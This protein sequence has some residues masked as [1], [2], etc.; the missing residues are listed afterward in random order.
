MEARYTADARQA[1]VLAQDEARGLGHAAVGAEHLLLGLLG[2]RDSP[3]GRAL[4][5][6][7]LTAD[8]ARADVERIL[9]R[10][11]R[12]GHGSIP[13]HP[14]AQRVLERALREAL[15]LG[16]EVVG[17]EH[18]V[19]ALLADPGSVA[20]QVL[21]AAG[22]P[23]A[24]RDRLLEAMNEPAPEGGA[25]DAPTVDR[26][27]DAVSVRLGDDVRALLRRAAGHALAADAHELTVEHV[28]RALGDAP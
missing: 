5:G 7:G 15:S 12:S 1:V 8:A 14:G 21:A 10:G 2:L 3:V 9:G 25:P 19:L 18:V 22:D 17:A 20:G 16:H 24:V 13:F 23:A 28:R 6:L 26:L 27:P 4:G 11:T